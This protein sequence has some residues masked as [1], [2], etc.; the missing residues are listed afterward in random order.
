MGCTL[1]HVPNS[2]TKGHQSYYQALSGL[3]RGK[4]ASVNNVSTQEHAPSINAGTF[5]S[6]GGA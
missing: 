1:H 3:R 4:Y 6:Y 5:Q 2:K